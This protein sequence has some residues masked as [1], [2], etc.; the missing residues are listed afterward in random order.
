MADPGWKNTLKDW[1]NKPEKVT[2]KGNKIIVKVPPETDC[3]DTTDNNAPFYWQKCS[4]DF[5]VVVKV[6]GGFSKDGDKG[7][8][9]VRLDDENWILTGMEHTGQHVN[10]VT[11][12]NINHTDWC[13]A[14]LPAT[15]AKDGVWFCFKRM[16]NCYECYYSLDARKWVQ[17]RQ[18]T[19]TE[20]PVLR[21]GL[22]CAC[23]SQ[24]EFRVT[25]ENYKCSNK[26]IF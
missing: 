4:G 1:D 19:L 25:F 8:I 20:R 23:P 26:V 12:A 15:S 14:T 13:M 2:N 18:G 21:V 5:Q 17:T 24:D 22:A 9:M 6:Y 16:G 7:G 10:N 11:L 3:G